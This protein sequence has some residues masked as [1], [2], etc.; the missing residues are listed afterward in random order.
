MP[1]WLRFQLSLCVGDANPDSVLRRGKEEKE[2]RQV[3]CCV[4]ESIISVIRR[5]HGVT[6]GTY[7]D[8]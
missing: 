1:G 2:E 8:G 7:H 4:T 3:D 6:S 5:D